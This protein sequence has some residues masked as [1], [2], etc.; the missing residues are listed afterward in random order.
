MTG[1]QLHAQIRASGRFAAHP[2]LALVTY[3][4]D[5]NAPGPSYDSGAEVVTV[6][7]VGSPW[8][9]FAQVR[10]ASNTILRVDQ[11]YP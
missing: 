11:F 4:A 9:L 8:R 2:T 10:S 5:T 6:I 1:A 3:G 7:G